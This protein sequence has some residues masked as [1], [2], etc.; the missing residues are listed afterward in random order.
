MTLGVPECKWSPG[1]RNIA[2]YRDR[3]EGP[4]YNVVLVA[5]FSRCGSGLPSALCLF[6]P[7]SSVGRRRLPRGPGR[8]RVSLACWCPSHFPS[9]SNFGFP[10]APPSWEHVS[11][12][13]L[14]LR[15]VAR[16]SAPRRR[17][18][19]KLV[20][21]YPRIDSRGESGPSRRE[22]GWLGGTCLTLVGPQSGEDVC[23]ATL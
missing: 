18:I 3:L 13:R 7:F 10:I 11:G 1:R 8:V 16:G 20:T 9:G 5:T 17:G 6:I 4:H 21:G 15:P 12:G 14:E 22:S 19:V 2:Y 23:F